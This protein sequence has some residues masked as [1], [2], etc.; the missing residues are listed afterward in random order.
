MQNSLDRVEIMNE[1]EFQD[2][3]NR[4]ESFEETKFSRISVGTV[5]MA[6]VLP[7]RRRSDETEKLMV[8]KGKLNTVNETRNRILH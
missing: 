1:V 4:W 2:G 3:S 8:R 5:R 6:Y 7:N